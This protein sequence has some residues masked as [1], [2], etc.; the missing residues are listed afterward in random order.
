MVCCAVLW[1]AVLQV[2]DHILNNPTDKT[3]VSLVFA[4]MSEGDILL[5]VTGVL[6]VLEDKAVTPHPYSTNSP[7]APSTSH[8]TIPA[9]ETDLRCVG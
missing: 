3:K 5:K 4:N 1:C 9:F 8:I 6:A 2:A 7:T